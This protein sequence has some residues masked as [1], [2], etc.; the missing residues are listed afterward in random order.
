MANA[1]QLMGEAMNP[2]NML[3]TVRPTPTK[4]LAHTAPFEM[5]EL[6]RPQISG[7]RNAP[8]SAPQEILIS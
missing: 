1:P 5:R 4:K 6:H 3:D 8:A 2:M 7:P